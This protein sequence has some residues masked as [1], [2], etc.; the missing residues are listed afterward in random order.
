MLLCLCPPLSSCTNTEPS[1]TPHNLTTALDTLPDSV[2]DAFGF[3]IDVPQSKI[4]NIRSQYRS[5]GERKSALLHTYLTS[6]PAPSWQHITDALYRCDVGKYHAV[7]ERVQRMF[8]TGDQYHGYTH[9]HTCIYSCAWYMYNTYTC[10]VY[11]DYEIHKVGKVLP[12]LT[13][14]PFTLPTC[15]SSRSPDTIIYFMHTL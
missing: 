5:D 12:N 13:S 7:L 3:E 6:H 9:L 4:G 14:L 8:P 10:T 1:L 2:W 15:T 11:T